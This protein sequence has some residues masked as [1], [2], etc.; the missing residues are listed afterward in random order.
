MKIEEHPMTINDAMYALLAE[1]EEG[2]VP[3]PL[4]Q[5]FLLHN[6]WA[7]LA[8][9]AGEEL[10]AEIDRAHAPTFAERVEP[11]AHRG[12]RATRAP[13]FAEA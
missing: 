2:E 9:L 6:L 1:L 5:R 7:D 4:R 8:R 13:Q 10:P 3:D 12:A 11:V